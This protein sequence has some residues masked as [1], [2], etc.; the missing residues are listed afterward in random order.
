[1]VDEDSVL[2]WYGSEASKSG[3]PA[4]VK[5]S[6]RAAKFVDWLQEAEEES[7]DEDSD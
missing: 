2:Q 5:L 3:S 7:S 4:E 6:E 1:M